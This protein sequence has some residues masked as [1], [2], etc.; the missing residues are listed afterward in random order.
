MDQTIIITKI[1]K[2]ERHSPQDNYFHESNIK[3]FQQ[4][5]LFNVFHVRLASRPFKKSIR[6]KV[7]WSWLVT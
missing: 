3:Q 6:T 7:V 1:R 4:M 2:M 5:T